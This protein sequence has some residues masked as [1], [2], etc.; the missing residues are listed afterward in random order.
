MDVNDLIPW[1]RGR[2]FPARRY[3]EEVS[4]FLALNREMNRLMDE[5]MR[6]FDMPASRFGWAG[7]WPHVDVSETDKEVRVTAELPGLEEKDVELTLNENVL[8]LRGEKKA[9]SE[10]PTYSERWHGRFERA[11]PLGTDIDP[12]KVKASFKNGVLTVTAEKRPD[13]QSKAKRISIGSG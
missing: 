10:S 2:N 7:A 9:E 5:F 11:I 6:G 8:T 4:P 13:S 3:A 1:R 12:D